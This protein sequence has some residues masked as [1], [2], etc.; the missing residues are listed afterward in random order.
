MTQEIYRVRNVEDGLWYV[1]Y[2]T[3]DDS[4][5]VSYVMSD[6]RWIIVADDSCEMIAFVRKGKERRDF[7]AVELEKILSGADVYP[8]DLSV[9]A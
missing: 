1:G 6:K 2:L 3:T 4:D 5:G 7:T 8:I 9:E